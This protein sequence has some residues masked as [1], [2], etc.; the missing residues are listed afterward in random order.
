MQRGRAI[1]VS[2]NGAASNLRTGNADFDVLAV[3]TSIAFHALIGFS[4]FLVIPFAPSARTIL[5]FAHDY[6]LATAL[7]T[8]TVS[9]LLASAITHA[10]KSRRQVA[11]SIVFEV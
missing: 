8:A 2:L 4:S 7:L 1:S 9:G 5:A 11:E 3:V 6:P 10:V